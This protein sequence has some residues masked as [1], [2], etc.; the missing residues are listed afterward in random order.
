MQG[1]IILAEKHSVNHR[2]SVA[3]LV[4]ASV[5]K[6]NPLHVEI[7]YGSGCKYKANVACG[8]CLEAH[9]CVAEKLICQNVY[10]NQKQT[11]EGCSWQIAN[12]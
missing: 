12:R 1:F 4:G 7:L 3:F 8:C 6:K 10:E 2:H 5:Y 11:D 9:C